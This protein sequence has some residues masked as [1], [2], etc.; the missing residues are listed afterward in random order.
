MYQSPVSS[1]KANPPVTDPMTKD[2]EILAI[3]T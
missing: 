2:P 1:A 3:T